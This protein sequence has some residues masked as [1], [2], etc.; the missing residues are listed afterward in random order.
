MFGLE[1]VDLVAFLG[2]AMEVGPLLS[3][4]LT[5]DRVDRFLFHANVFPMWNQKKE[6]GVAMSFMMVEHANLHRVWF[7]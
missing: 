4:Y 6:S 2:K 3:F 1:S 7:R 5:F